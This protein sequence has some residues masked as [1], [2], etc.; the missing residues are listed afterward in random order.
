VSLGAA[1]VL[2]VAIG[3]TYEQRRRDVSRLRAGYDALD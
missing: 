2:L 3:A 1:G